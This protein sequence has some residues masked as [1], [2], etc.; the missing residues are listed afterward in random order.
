MKTH[1]KPKETEK[2][3]CHICQRVFKSRAICDRH[4][5]K[6][7]ETTAEEFQANKKLIK[8]ERK[9]R[10]KELARQI[11]V[12]Q[13][14][15]EQGLLDQRLV[16]H[17]LETDDSDSDDPDK[18]SGKRKQRKPNKVIR[19]FSQD[20]KTKLN[21]QN[22]EQ[23]SCTYCNET[24]ESIALLNSHIK[25]HIQQQEPKEIDKSNE[26]ALFGLSQS[27][28]EQDVTS[29][30]KMVNVL[31]NEIGGLANE[32]ASSPKGLTLPSTIDQDDSSKA[33][34]ESAVVEIVFMKNASDTA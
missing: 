6:H 30:N 22:G 31:M 5:A 13:R 9:L 23:H 33:A 7:G 17:S 20:L 15:V 11:L 19:R 25:Q 4:I 18:I 14:L 2:A 29:G 34:E 1:D 32:K 27:S 3:T 26:L 24:F 21:Q 10:K 12:E 16:E 28:S 8:Q